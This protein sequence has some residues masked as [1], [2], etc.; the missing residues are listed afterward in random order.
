[1]ASSNTIDITVSLKDRITSTATKISNTLGFLGTRTKDLGDDVSKTTAKTGKF[2]SALSKVGKSAGKLKSVFGNLKAAVAA[3][4]VVVTSKNLINAANEQAKAVIGMETA[5]KA[6]GSYTPELSQNLQDTASAM[7]NITNFG[8]EATLAGQKFLVTY[9]NI[10]LDVLPRAT[11]A[12]V[13]LAA[14][15]GGG[16]VNAANMLGKASMGMTG[17]LRMAGISV[18]KAAYEARGFLGVLEEI[19]AQAGGQAEAQRKAT[20]SIIAMGNSFGDLKEKAGDFIKIVAEPIFRTLL[21]E[22]DSLNNKIAE[23]Q[24]GDDFKVWAADMALKVVESLASIGKGALT[25]YGVVAPI[26]VKLVE[27]LKGAW[28]WFNSLPG[29]LRTSGLVLALFGGTATKLAVVGMTQLYN[30]SNDLTSL[31]THIGHKVLGTKE[32]VSTLASELSVL[33]MRLAALKAPNALFGMAD[34]ETIK[35]TEDQIEEL[36]E[37]LKKLHEEQNKSPEPI[38]GVV[39]VDSIQKDVDSGISLIDKL[40]NSVRGVVSTVKEEAKTAGLGI[41][42]TLIPEIRKTYDALISKVKAAYDAAKAEVDSYTKKVLESE[43]KIQ[44]IRMS[45]ADKIRNLRR[46][47]MTDEA[48]YNDERAQA[49]EKLSLA[50]Q[51]LRDGD[52]KAAQQYASQAESLYAN[53]AREITK[54]V[55][56]E[57]VVTQ[58]IGKSVSIASKGLEDVRDVSIGIEK[59][60]RDTYKKL[61]EEATQTM[62][63]IGT[64][65]D[66][67]TEE[68]E[69]KIEI[70]L[71]GLSEAQKKL[72]TLTEKATKEVTVKITEKRSYGGVVGRYAKGGIFP[73]YGGGDKV[74][75]LAEAGEGFVRKEAIRKY[76]ES[77]FNAYNS[78]S[79]PLASVA[80]SLKARIGGIVS[81]KVNVPVMKFQSGGVVPTSL[82][83][84][85]RVEIAVGSSAFPVMAEINVIEELKNALSTEKLM[86]SN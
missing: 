40:M 68:R 80:E 25:V 52:L 44:S 16:M 31:F 57:T 81:Q 34:A 42:D 62:D 24:M 59:V 6:M 55:G 23:F 26:V 50:R 77:F 75:V 73:G 74:S 72:D 63:K 20:G 37:K 61:E 84:M 7:Q 69:A 12:M 18:S 51:A 5:L 58:S 2:D 64:K 70:E 27:S 85:G 3:L 67:L 60:Q 19:E 78:M 82:R 15:T 22:F 21:K 79:L 9:A 49:D 41:S 29:W 13:D 56:G 53:L 8:D 33:K 71:L 35:K 48:S 43:N 36:T 66:D 30:A 10:G 83:D 32:N 1:M 39:D 11:K 76:G 45:T 65:L 14:L 46:R 28:D 47:T 86:R 38:S 17:R 4:A 54:D